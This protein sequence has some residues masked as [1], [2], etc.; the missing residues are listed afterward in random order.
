MPF[1]VKCPGCKQRIKWLVDD[2]PDDCP[3][4]GHRLVSDRA[5]SDVVMPNILAFSTRCQDGVY[6]AMEKAS[7][8]RVYEAAEMA[9]C[10]PSEMSS[11]KITNLRDNMK[12]GEIAAIPVV[13]DVTRQMDAVRAMNPNAH[14]GFG[15]GGGVSA[16]IGFSESVPTGPYPSAGARTQQAFRRAHAERMSGQLARGDVTSDL[17]AN[18]ITRNPN[19][20]S[21]V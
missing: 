1:V 3:A 19:Y 20:R 2:P 9:G 6:K 13:N 8:Q 14:V 17:P 21:R 7:E 18:E 16:G 10:S 11:L 4:C 5:D 12:Q 15:T